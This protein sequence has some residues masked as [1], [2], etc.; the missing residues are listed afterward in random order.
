MNLIFIYTYIFLKCLFIWLC[1]I[2]V[3][4]CGIE[5]PD[6]GSNPGP[7]HWECKVLATGLPGKSPW[8]W[9]WAAWREA[10]K[11]VPRL[12][13]SLQLL[14]PVVLSHS[15]HFAPHRSCGCSSMVAISSCWWGCSQCTRA[16]STTTAFPSQSTSSAPG[17]TCLPCTAPVT[18]Q[19]SRGRWC[20]GSECLPGCQMVSEVEGVTPG[21]PRHHR[22]PSPLF[23]VTATASSG[24]TACCSWIPVCPGCSA[25]L[26]LSALI[27]W[28]YASP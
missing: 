24:T 16:S 22:R 5:F 8:A 1:W 27:P 28:V 14:F 9:L 15:P 21:P 17:G 12:T 25:A 20:F 11:N 10:V 18:A 3:A 2:L 13:R 23:C 26:T 4:A 19:R 6:Q 7:L